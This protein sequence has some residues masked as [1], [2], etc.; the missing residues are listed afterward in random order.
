M[1]HFGEVTDLQSRLTQ[2]GFKF[3]ADRDDDDGDVS[4]EEQTSYIESAAD[5]ADSEI[6]MAIAL[7]Y[8]ATVAKGNKWLRFIWVDL[9]TVRAFENGGREAPSHFIEE[10][11]R[12]RKQLECVRN[13][14][15]TIPGLH[16]IPPTFTSF[17]TNAIHIPCI[18]GYDPSVN[19]ETLLHMGNGNQNIIRQ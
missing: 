5:Q 16:P 2:H 6:E 17:P 7:K 15:V 4:S 10:R 19:A 18:T 14:E 1:D 13:G 3:V 8:N 9:A 12:A 11:D